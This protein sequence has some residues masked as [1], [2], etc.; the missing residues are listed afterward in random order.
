MRNFTTQELFKKNLY[1][2]NYLSSSQGVKKGDFIA[3]PHSTGK[4]RKNEEKLT[5]EWFCRRRFYPGLASRQEPGQEKFKVLLCYFS[6]LPN[7]FCR[8]LFST[9]LPFTA[10]IPLF[11][12]SSTS[13]FPFLTAI[14][15]R[16]FSLSS[17]IA[18][19]FN[20]SLYCFPI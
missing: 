12:R 16:S 11:S 5:S 10:A 7:H 13:L 3:I 19:I 14:P 8:I 18:V 4:I 1:Y 6:V 15:R 2:T 20:V 17:T 9:A